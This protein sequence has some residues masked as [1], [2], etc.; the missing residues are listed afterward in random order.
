MESILQHI[1]HFAADQTVANVCCHDANGAL[2]CFSCYYAYN[3]EQQLLHFKSADDTL[4]MQLMAKHPDVAGTILP[5][6][7]N[8]LKVQGLQFSGTLLDTN[9]N[10]AKQAGKRYHAKFPLAIGMD[11]KVHTIKLSWVKM[12]DNTLGFGTK[13]VWDRKHSAEPIR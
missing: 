6:K 1:N 10:E 5:D 7:L 11:G 2:H 13:L 9:D 12:T 8:K 3:A 4:H